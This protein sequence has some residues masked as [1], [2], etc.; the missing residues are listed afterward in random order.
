[1]AQTPSQPQPTQ[2][3]ATDAIQLALLI[4]R[5]DLR[6]KHVPEAVR[7]AVTAVLRRMTDAQAGQIAGRAERKK[8]R[9]RDGSVVRNA[10]SC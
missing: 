3:P 5:S 2:P 7:P 6:L 8:Y 4:R 1:M 10:S 9:S